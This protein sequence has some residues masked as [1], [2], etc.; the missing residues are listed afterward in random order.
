MFSL[1]LRCPDSQFTMVSANLVVASTEARIYDQHAADKI[2]VT[3]SSISHGVG[4]TYR[5]AKT[6]RGGSFS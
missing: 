3:V 2:F 6:G 1:I 4:S 5:Q